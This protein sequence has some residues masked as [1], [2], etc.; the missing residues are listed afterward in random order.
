MNNVKNIIILY[1]T[2]KLN[3]IKLNIS[4]R[5]SVT[6]KKNDNQLFTHIKLPKG[7]VIAQC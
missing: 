6:L 3:L 1:K 2:H 5:R 7:K 4:Y